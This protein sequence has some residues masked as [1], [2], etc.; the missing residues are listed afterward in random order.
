[1]RLLLVFL[2]AVDRSR[3]RLV[4]EALVGEAGDSYLSVLLDSNVP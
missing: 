1:M 2:A 3:T 4:K